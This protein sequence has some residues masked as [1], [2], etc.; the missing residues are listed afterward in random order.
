MQS[1]LISL[2]LVVCVVLAVGSLV[3]ERTESEHK[4]ELSELLA[5]EMPSAISL[6]GA[7]AWCKPREGL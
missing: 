3:G 6:R 7:L 1:S 4:P 5:K 2:V